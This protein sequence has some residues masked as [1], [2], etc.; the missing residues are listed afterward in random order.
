VS[1]VTSKN[2]A[3][4][5]AMGPHGWLF[6]LWAASALAQYPPPPTGIKVVPSSLGGGAQ[7]SYKEVFPL[8]VC[9]RQG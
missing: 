1:V 6:C 4:L 9:D 5:D 7:I 2:Y 3:I 8:W